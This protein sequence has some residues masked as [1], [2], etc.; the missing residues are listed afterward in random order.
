MGKNRE[1]QRLK[2]VGDRV[3][4]DPDTGGAR[5][6]AGLYLPPSVTASQAVKSGRVVAVGPGTP[7]PDPEGSGE[8]WRESAV[9]PRYLPMEVETGDFVLFLQKSA[10][11]IRY[12]DR[13][14]LIVPLAGILLIEREDPAAEPDLSDLLE[15]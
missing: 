12:G 11:E 2:V 8:P 3:L 7:L 1:L 10:I 5:T 9:K 4:I 6:S 14:Y 15:S 13:E